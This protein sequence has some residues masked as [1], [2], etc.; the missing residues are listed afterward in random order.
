MC[1]IIETSQ[2][3]PALINCIAGRT[4]RGQNS[5]TIPDDVLWS[6]VKEV[7]MRCWSSIEINNESIDSIILFL[8]NIFGEDFITKKNQGI[9]ITNFSDT[10]KE[11]MSSYFYSD[12]TKWYKT[13]DT[14]C[15]GSISFQ[16]N[17]V[18]YRDTPC[19]ENIITPCRIRK[20]LELLYPTQNV[21]VVQ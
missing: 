15:D 3:I 19:S 16:E 12:E 10:I 18:E 17:S 6:I 14:I 7:Q 4:K 1:T 13:L 5:F 11:R 8:Q 20:S 9:E 21:A 2:F